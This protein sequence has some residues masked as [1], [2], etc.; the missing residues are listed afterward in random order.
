MLHPANIR[1]ITKECT[2]Q[3]NDLPFYPSDGRKSRP[4]ILSN[5]TIF[6]YQKSRQLTAESRKLQYERNYFSWWIRHKASS[7]YIGR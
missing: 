1:N 2:Q 4:T 3:D 6:K 7:A 5:L